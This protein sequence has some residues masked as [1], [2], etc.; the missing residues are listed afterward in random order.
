MKFALLALLG[1][2]TLGV[3]ASAQAASP[4][5]TNYAVKTAT[6]VADK[7]KKADAKDKSTHKNKK[8]DKKDK[9]P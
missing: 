7:E 2:F 1:V 8:K 3:T 9:K 6:L 4:V 5:P